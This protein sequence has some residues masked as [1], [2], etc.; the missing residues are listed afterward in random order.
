MPRSSSE[1]SHDETVALGSEPAVTRPRL[2][3]DIDAE[4]CVIGAGVAGLTAAREL[5]RRG[6][7]VVLLEAQ[8][9][10]A[11]ASGRGAGLVAPGYATRMDR[12][13][14][15]V[16]PDAA[17]ELWQLSKGGADY[18]RRTIAE[19]QIAGTKPVPGRLTV[20]KVDD[21]A[22]ARRA[23][24]HYR[25][26]FGTKTEFWPTARVRA[27]L[28]S[29]H[30]FQGIFDYGSYHIHALNY[31]R[32]L[33]FAAEA[34]G[35]RIFE[36]TAVTALDIEGVRKRVE[37]A[38]GRVRAGDIVLA[39]GGAIE[40]IHPP[41]AGTT[42]AS[43]LSV[44]VTAPIAGLSDMVRFRGAV[45]HRNSAAET[46]YVAGDRLVW[47]APVS[48]RGLIVH[49]REQVRRDIAQLYPRLTIEI[50]RV[51]SG[52]ISRAIHRMPQ[53][54]P[55]APGL[56]LAGAFA[57]HGLAAGTMGGDL[58]ARAIH[59]GDDRWR[60]F[61]DYG[62]VWAGGR[63]SRTV[64]SVGQLARGWRDEIGESFSRGR[65]RFRVHG[66]RQRAEMR[67]PSGSPAAP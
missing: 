14:E 21:E 2:T 24:E 67:K 64:I 57:H 25:R 48:L 22:G 44:A 27:T 3:N 34:A 12:I 15:R 52:Q 32:G 65:E 26:T 61:G 23:A 62:L 46:Y 13:L 1:H 6:F 8:S 53:L 49:Q 31:V 29:M 17:R 63:L 33:A 47:R 37:A 18:I 28:A 66:S 59:E 38:P 41:L 30:Y 43:D 7:N 5:A 16:G 20:N 42:I 60:L 50:D 54:G 51:C 45:S 9:V 55:L 19:A 10:G 39:A 4:I 56:W 11:G 35:V 40:R 58:I 36:N